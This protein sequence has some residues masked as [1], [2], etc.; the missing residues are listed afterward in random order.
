MELGAKGDVYVADTELGCIKEFDKRGTYVSSFGSVGYGPGQF[1]HPFGL[2]PDGRGN[3][4]VC[5]RGN[6]RI[7]NLVIDRVFPSRGAL[8][9]R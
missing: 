3:L 2:L 9:G 6:S 1:R 7:Y 8:A 4:Y 5:D